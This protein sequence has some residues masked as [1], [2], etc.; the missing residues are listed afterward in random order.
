MT[1]HGLWGSIEQM[2]DPALKPPRK[3]AS[4]ELC[5]RGLPLTRHHLIPRTLHGRKQ[6]RRRF[7]R[8]ELNSQILW[9]CRPCH[10]KVHAVFAEKDLA[11]YFHSRERLLAHPEIRRFVEW[12][13][14]KPEG[15]K[16]KKQASRR[17]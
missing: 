15:F 4:C 12:L 6:I 7:S 11:E 2:D 3:P 1:V 10:S 9:I 16:P 8:N 13:A 5:A 17:C 14:G